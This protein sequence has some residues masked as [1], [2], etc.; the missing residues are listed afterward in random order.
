M[1]RLDLRYWKLCYPIFGADWHLLHG[2]DSIQRRIYS[3]EFYLA[4]IDIQIPEFSGFDVVKQLRA[5][6]LS[7]KLQ[8]W[9]IDG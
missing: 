5:T 1:M 9:A 6:T 2:G 8:Y 4:V 7:K 3:W